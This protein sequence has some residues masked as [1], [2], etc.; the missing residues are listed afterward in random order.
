MEGFF[1]GQFDAG[2][3]VSFFKGIYHLPDVPRYWRRLKRTE[4]PAE[5]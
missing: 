5:K 1:R 4:T 3:G 2:R